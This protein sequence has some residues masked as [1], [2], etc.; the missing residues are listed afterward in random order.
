M[1]LERYINGFE[2]GAQG[3]M[4]FAG[5]VS[6]LSTYR[7]VV[8]DAAAAR[9]GSCYLK[10]APTN[11][12]PNQTFLPAGSVTGTTGTVTSGNHKRFRSRAYFKLINSSFV[13]GNQ[14]IY[15][16]GLGP[17]VG[18]ATILNRSAT[19]ANCGAASVWLN[20]DGR[21]GIYIPPATVP[22]S[23]GLQALS[24]G[25]LTTNQWYQMILDVD[26]AVSSNTV[27]SVSCRVVNEGGVA[28]DETITASRAIGNTDVMGQVTFGSAGSGAFQPGYTAYWDDVVWSAASNADA[29]SQLTLPVATRIYPV[30]ATAIYTRA[31][32]VTAGPDQSVLFADGAVMAGV[33]TSSVSNSWGGSNVADVNEVPVDTSGGGKGLY[34][35]SSNPS[36]SE[37][38]FAHTTAAALGLTSI[39]AW[40]VYVNGAVASGTGS[41]D[42]LLGDNLSQTNTWGTLYADN[43]GTRNPN[44]L[45][46]WT[47]YT[48]AA[49][50]AMQFGVR[51]ENGTQQSFLGNILSEVLAL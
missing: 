25:V 14:F 44:A 42:A 35:E 36:G 40:K 7:D 11:G 39:I 33:V 31:F 21:F 5:S 18:Y 41:I 1:A 34:F 30:L 22:G 4:L 47:G 10:I 26:L 19:I 23:D 49:F 15:L 20:A 32:S 13:F 51:K 12:I 45:L 2:N 50:D 9:T 16:F 48:A 27:V 17:G 29:V 3:E 38:R 6:V 8:K 24:S 28:L 37:V 46:D 43:G